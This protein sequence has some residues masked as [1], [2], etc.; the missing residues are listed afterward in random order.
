MHTGKYHGSRK[1][2]IEAGVGTKAESG[3]DFGVPAYQHTAGLARVT[4]EGGDCVLLMFVLA[5]AQW[6]IP[7]MCVRS[8]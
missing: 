8:G 2:A 4:G 7:S 3:E 1:S 5:L 6:L